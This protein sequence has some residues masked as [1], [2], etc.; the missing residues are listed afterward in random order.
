MLTTWD[1][2]CFTPLKCFTG[3][4]AHGDQH[5]NV[6]IR[7]SGIQ[8]F[9]HALSCSCSRLC[10]MG[11]SSS[12]FTQAMI[13][14]MPLSHPWSDSVW[15]Q[16]W[17]SWWMAETH[18]KW[19]WRDIRPSMVTH[20]W[21]TCSAF[22]PSKVHTHTQQWTHTP[23][24]HTRSSGQP[25]MLRRPG[26]NWGF[27]SLLKGTSVVVL[28]VERALYIHSPHLQFLPARD[29]NSQPLGYKSNSLTIRPRL[30]L[31]PSTVRH[32][33]NFCSYLLLPH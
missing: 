25:F 32:F 10:G 33:C 22:N 13:A 28:R 2:K 5:T 11:A 26:S 14:S 19:M 4:C 29:S 24:T 6:W 1:V 23:W 27:G 18:W 12:L 7:H 17:G 20:T 16:Q 21:N 15:L 30:P 31:T 9:P 8:I 3:S